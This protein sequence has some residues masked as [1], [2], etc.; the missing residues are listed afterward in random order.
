VQVNATTR[1][2]ISAA[3][4]AS[5][6]LRVLSRN[7]TLDPCL[8]KALLPPSHGRSADLDALRH[9]VRRPPI[10]RDKHDARPLD[11]LSRPIVRS[12]TIAASCSRSAAFRITHIGPDPPKP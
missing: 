4:G 9:A 1:A 11:M 3:I 5:P 12:A 10:R 2:A 8:G 7:R 6:G